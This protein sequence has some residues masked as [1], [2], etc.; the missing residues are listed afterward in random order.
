MAQHGHQDTQQSIGNMSQRLAMPLSFGPKRC[1]H[2]AEVCIT[3]HG[4]SRHVIESLTSPRITTAPH[5]HHSALATLLR[6]RGHPAM[7][8]SHLIVALGQGLA[9]FCKEP[10]RNVTSDS[11]QR[12]HHGHI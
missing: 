4:H 8:A 12:Q 2:V 7:R 11:R 6:D 3:L 9:S 10:G 1:L 5:H